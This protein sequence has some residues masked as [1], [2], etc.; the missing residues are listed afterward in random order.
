MVFLQNVGSVQS[1]EFKVWSKNKQ[2]AKV[3][4]RETYRSKCQDRKLEATIYNKRDEKQMGRN[5]NQYL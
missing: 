5:R 1:A 2:N 3:V 4:K